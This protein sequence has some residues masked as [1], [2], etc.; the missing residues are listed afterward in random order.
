MNILLAAVNAK[1]I[2]TSLSVRCLRRYAEKSAGLEISISEFTINQT[3]GEILPEI[4]KQNPDVIGFSCYLW[5]ISMI[6][7]LTALIKEISPQTK[8]IWG[9]PEVSARPEE[10]FIFPVDFII[11]G[12]GER[13]FT[14][15]IKALESGSDLAA[16]HGI[17]YVNGGNVIHNPLGEPLDLSEIPFPYE[18]ADRTE[19]KIFYYE[20][21]RG[22]PFN[23][24]YCLSSLEKGVRFAP[25]SK[26]KEDLS[27]FLSWRVRQVKF[28]DRTFNCRPEFAA[29]I[30]RFLISNDNGVTNFHFEVAAE[31]L[32]NEITSLLSS[33][34]KGLFQL[35]IGV[36]STNPETLSAVKR[37]TELPL[38][39]KQVDILKENNNLHLH[40]DLIAGL[41]DEDYK[42]F[43]K[44]F[45]DVYKLRPH[46]LQL[47]FLKVL[48]GSGMESLCK[49]YEIHFSPY[50]PYEVLFTSCLSFD[51][52][53]QL[54]GVEAMLELYYNSGKFQSSVRLLCDNFPSPFDFYKA[55][56]DFLPEVDYEVLGSRRNA[57]RFL[58]DFSQKHGINGSKL[59][60]IVKFDMLLHEGMK[61]NPPWLGI[62]QSAED[63]EKLYL[64]FQN[65]D[66]IKSIF[67][68][69][70]DCPAKQ[71]PKLIHGEVFPFNPITMEEK[72]TLI[73]FNYRRRDL[74]GNADFTEW[75]R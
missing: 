74:Y 68:E 40:L 23:C 19:N 61:T 62:S 63:S 7:K 15:L 27:I 8:I 9:G 66:K 75:L 58:L 26:V 21:S 42:T 51:D 60:Y 47:G 72:E 54:K 28:V 17:S 13:A 11:R 44:S 14:E 67:P 55:L 70:D 20:A 5:N 34:R 43:Q 2:H 52:L 37:R 49:K 12:E 64:V 48:K 45:N 4:I 32:T 30:I 16:V 41:P 39:K 59:P 29:E 3:V 71:L 6:R 1:Y 35:E 10:E 38:I 56:A 53:Q 31:L 18:E 22:C 73:L 57:Y 36:Q 50:P 33:A 24:Q 69:Y 25:I 46:Q 65:A